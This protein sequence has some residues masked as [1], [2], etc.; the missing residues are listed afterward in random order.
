MKKIIHHLYIIQY[1]VKTFCPFNFYHTTNEKILMVNFSQTRVYNFKAQ[2]CFS[3]S[4]A[5]LQSLTR[6]EFQLL[7]SVSRASRAVA[8]N[9]FSQAMTRLVSPSCA[10]FLN[11]LHLN[12]NQI[13][14]CPWHAFHVDNPSYSSFDIIGIN[15]RC[16]L[17]AR[18]KV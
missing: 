11:V 1:M 12:Q 14:T 10:P 15:G 6:H 18:T 5:L 13:I 2:K 3:I 4:E 7:Y 8:P 17:T 16:V 9:P